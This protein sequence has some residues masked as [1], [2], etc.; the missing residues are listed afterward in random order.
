ML[1]GP[2]GSGKTPLGESL[3]VHGLGGRPC[4]HFDFGASLREAAAGCGDRWVSAADV[5]LIRRVLEAGSLLEE[6][7]FGLA[8]RLFRRFLDRRG[9]AGQQWVVLNGLPRTVPQACAMERLAAVRMVVCL[10]CPAEVASER[11]RRDAGGDRAGRPDDEREAVA[12][13]L[14]LYESETKPLIAHYRGAGA[15]VEEIDVAV[16][17][18]TEAIRER[19]DGMLESPVAAA[20][21]T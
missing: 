20:V 1:M 21:R 8:E 5:A 13:R 3:D 16:D 14:R 11:I 12:R 10:R 15:R 4:V 2:T 19:M 9:V 17:T 6:R 7:E 18:R